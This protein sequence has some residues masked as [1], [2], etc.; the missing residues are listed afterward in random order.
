MGL[1]KVGCTGIIIISATI[2][3][4]IYM[5]ENGDTKAP[6]IKTSQQIEEKKELPDPV[7]LKFGLSEDELKRYADQDVKFIVRQHLNLGKHEVI[8]SWNNDLKFWEYELYDKDSKKM[9]GPY[10][11]VN[12]HNTFVR[13]DAKGRKHKNEYYATYRY[14]LEKKEWTIRSLEINGEKIKLKNPKR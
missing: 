7:K 9:T 2:G 1:I 6:E 8:S 3:V 5:L 14:D 12:I 11:G 13:K 4:A 10:A